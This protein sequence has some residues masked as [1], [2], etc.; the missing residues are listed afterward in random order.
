MRC[1]GPCPDRAT[2]PTGRLS[3]LCADRF[4]TYDLS[5]TPRQS[6][7]HLALSTTNVDHT[8]A[9][10]QQFYRQRKNLFFIFGVNTVREFLLPPVG[11]A[12]PSFEH[13]THEWSVAHGP[14]CR[15]HRLVG[16]AR[17]AVLLALL[18]ALLWGLGGFLGGQASRRAA[19]IPVLAVEL[20][21]GTTVIIPLAFLTAH[22][23]AWVDLL[24]GGAAGFFGLLGVTFFY[25]G[26]RGPMATV[27]PVAGVVSAALPLLWG[28]GFGERLSAWQVSG[29]IL[30]LLSIM[31]ISNTGRALHGISLTPLVNGV[32][33]GA[34][35]GAGYIVLDATDPLTAPWPIVGARLLPALAVCAVA[36]VAHQPLSAVGPARPW[37]VGAGL[38]TVLASV[39]F[40][41]AINRGLLSISSVLSC[42]HPAVTVILA[43]LFLRERMS[44][45]QATGLAVAVAA[46]SMITVG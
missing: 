19:L 34:G 13:V 31:L 24:I 14:S 7:S 15:R 45:C 42:L 22:R 10:G 11:V 44:L 27:A 8:P 21:A 20:L 17:M 37:S 6:P 41:A 25:L 32:L 30:G 4:G 40:L 2:P 35:F 33:A 23:F 1:G 43:R 5:H 26:L 9:T 28:V 38:S 3:Y 46:I 12:L 16:S 36:L 39:A 18:A 29:V